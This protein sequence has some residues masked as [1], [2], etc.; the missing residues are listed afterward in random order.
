VTPTQ[1]YRRG[2]MTVRSER[3]KVRHLVRAVGEASGATI[4]GMRGRGW[5]LEPDAMPDCKRCTSLMGGR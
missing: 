3:G 4:C 2:Y 5:T 1:A